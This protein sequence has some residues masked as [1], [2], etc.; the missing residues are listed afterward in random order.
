MFSKKPGFST[1]APAYDRFSSLISSQLVLLSVAQPPFNPSCV[2]PRC[3]YAIENQIKDAPNQLFRCSANFE[4]QSQRCGITRIRIVGSDPG[5]YRSSS[6]LH[7][8]CMCTAEMRLLGFQL[9][10]CGSTEFCSP[11]YSATVVFRL[12]LLL[13]CFCLACLIQHNEY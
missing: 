1:G 6:M 10:M 11:L 5:I 7:L 3:I 13:C 9:P 4:I 2:I 12:L 8:T